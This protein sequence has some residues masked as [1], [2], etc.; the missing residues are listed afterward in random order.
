MF[1]FYL[2]RII[3]MT[4]NISFV[5]QTVRSRGRSSGI[6]YVSDIM[7]YEEDDFQ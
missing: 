2:Y 1:Y 5:S 6:Y 3:E 7:Q 4:V